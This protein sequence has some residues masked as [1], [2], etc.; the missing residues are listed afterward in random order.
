[1]AVSIEG[2]VAFAICSWSSNY[3]FREAHCLSTDHAGPPMFTLSSFAFDT[4]DENSKFYLVRLPSFLIFCSTFTT[5][6][7]DTEV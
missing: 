4:I 5:S 3:G 6:N 7:F 1:M 2:R